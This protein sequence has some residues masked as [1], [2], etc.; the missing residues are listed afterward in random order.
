MKEEISHDVRGVRS[1]SDNPTVSSF[2]SGSPVLNRGSN[3]DRTLLRLR[4]RLPYRCSRFLPVP[5]GTTKSRTTLVT[6]VHLER[7]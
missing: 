7:R 5:P 3:Y 4:L 6:G 1:G 2:D